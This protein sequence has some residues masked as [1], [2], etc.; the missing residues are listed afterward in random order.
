MRRTGPHKATKRARRGSAAEPHPA[1][2]AH[3]GSLGTSPNTPASF[4]AALKHPV[5][6]LEA[7]VRFTPENE[8]YLSHDPL[9][10]PLPRG[11]MRLKDL[12]K[13]AAAHPKVRLNLDL[14]EYTGIREMADLIRR[15]KMTSRVILTGVGR[16]A[17]RWVRASGSGLPH[18]LNARPNAWQRLTAV[19][20]AGFARTV[21]ACGARGLNTHHLFVTRRLARALA[22]AGLSLSVWTVDGEREMHRMLGLDVDNITTNRIDTLLALRDGRTR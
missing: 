17:V 5:D 3:A 22:R 15:S 21:K 13:L 14:K 10:I 4:K 16:A 19:G 12:L 18:L 2:T 8:A 6:Y 20:A 11:A 7:D 1:V 9:P